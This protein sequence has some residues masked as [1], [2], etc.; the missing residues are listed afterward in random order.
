[1]PDDRRQVTIRLCEADMAD[2]TAL[3]DDLKK[4]LPPHLTGAAKSQ[5]LGE[6]ILREFV[7]AYKAN[8]AAGAQKF[9]EGKVNS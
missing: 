7:E 9:I 2:W 3:I 4:R 5:Y 8:P 1:M 6:F